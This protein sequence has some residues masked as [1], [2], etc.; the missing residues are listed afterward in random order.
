MDFPDALRLVLDLEGGRSDNPHDPGGR[1]NHGITQATYDAWCDHLAVPRQDVHEIPM[2]EVERIYRSEYWLKAGCDRLPGR[3]GV[4]HFQA[5]VLMGVTGAGRILAAV[6]WDDAYEDL[7]V[8]AYLTLQREKLR[9]IAAKAP[10]FL[11]G[12]LNRINKTWK[13]VRRCS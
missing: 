1:T 3:L 6:E 9:G 11:A 7:R 5:A 2:A 12:W 13:F 10:M 4:V 8:Y